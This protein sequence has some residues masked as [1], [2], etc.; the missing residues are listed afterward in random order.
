M[1]WTVSVSK[2]T[3]NNNK[4]V[5]L[6]YTDGARTIVDQHDITSTTTFPSV[7]AIAANKIAWL[8]AQD[9]AATVIP[10]GVI[11]PSLLVVPPVVVTQPPTVTPEDPLLVTWR[12]GWQ[13]LQA[14][15]RLV[16]AGIIP[17]NNA[18]LLALTQTLKD[19]FKVAYLDSI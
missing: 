2:S 12:A 11:D 1:A 7:C 8:T 6:I 17:A 19:T 10:D 18:Q 9:Q 15:N 3:Q 5:Q 4:I 13:K 16:A 14:G